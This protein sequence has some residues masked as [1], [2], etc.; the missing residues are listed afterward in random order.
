MTLRAGRDDAADIAAA[1]VNHIEGDGGAEIDDDGGRA[2]DAGDGD[3]VGEAVG[4]DGIGPGIIDAEA[5]GGFGSQDETSGVEGGAREGANQGRHLRDDAAD[6]GAGQGL[7]AEE[8]GGGGLGGAVLP[9]GRGEV[10]MTKD[11]GGI[12]QA[13]MRMRVADVEKR[14]HRALFWGKLGKSKC[15]SMAVS[16]RSRG[17]S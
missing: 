17:R 5:G 10:R 6:S 12:R 7:A 2:A 15:M 3:G 9:A 13:D 8:A 1:L 4:A 11:P 16:W 14:E